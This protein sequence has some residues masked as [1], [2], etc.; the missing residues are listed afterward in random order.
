[1]VLSRTMTD[2]AGQENPH[3]GLGQFGLG[4]KE[5][6]GQLAVLGRQALLY[7][8]GVQIFSVM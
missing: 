2:H 7:Y 5:K 3:M 4:P 8:Y 6:T 1:M